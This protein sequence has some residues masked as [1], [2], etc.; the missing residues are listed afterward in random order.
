ME[1]GDEEA[2]IALSGISSVLQGEK[3]Y[4][5]LIYPCHSPDVQRWFQLDV[6]R[7]AGTR[8]GVVISHTDVTSRMLLK[9]ALQE[10]KEV[11]QQA[12]QSANSA[13]QTMSRLLRSVA[14]EF[15]TPLS[16]LTINSDI[17][18]IHDGL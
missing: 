9:K 8:L 6:S 17:L 7:F 3:D 11:L 16:L 12:L 5:S 18:R 10:S 15:R 1:S 2:E 13:N 14:H 4:F